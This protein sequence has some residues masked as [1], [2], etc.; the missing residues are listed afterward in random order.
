LNIHTTS[1]DIPPINTVGIDAKKRR[2]RACSRSLD[3]EFRATD[4]YREATEFMEK[5]DGKVTCFFSM[6]LRGFPVKLSFG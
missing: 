5:M 6:T 2:L 4:F 1:T 3:R